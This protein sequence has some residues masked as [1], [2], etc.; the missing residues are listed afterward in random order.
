MDQLLAA[1]AEI[2][3]YFPWLSNGN[4]D[5]PVST[6]EVSLSHTSGYYFDACLPDGMDPRVPCPP[7]LIEDATAAAA[8]GGLDFT[9]I[10]GVII[11]SPWC[12]G[13]W[14]NGPISISRPGVSGTFQRAYD[15]ECD[16]SAILGLVNPPGPSR[17]WWGAWAHEIGHQLEFQYGLFNGAWNGHPGNYSSGYELMDSCYPCD[18]TSFSLSAPPVVSNIARVFP[19]WLPSSKV[20]TIDSS[21]SG[22]TVVL[23]PLSQDPVTTPA[24]Q[25]IQV[26]I[27]PGK[28]YMVEARRRLRADSLAT[29]PGIWDE[30]INIVD[31]EESRIPPALQ[32][33]SCNTSVPGGCVTDCA[34]DSR[35]GACCFLGTASCLRRGDAPDYCWPYP[36]W[37]VGDAFNDVAN[38][39]Q[40]RVDSE[41]GDCSQPTCGYAVT[42]T[43]G[44]TSGHPDI[45][46]LPWLTPPM[47]TW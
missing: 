41:V 10:G 24:A 36:L 40:I 9:G 11:L 43:R 15:F 23:A 28:Y 1:G 19:G 25:A 44:A 46:V 21:V 34:H 6:T 17:V 35:C 8:A 47:N 37:H 20:V 2:Q 33:N 4:L 14:T 29:A 5:M 12:A 39:I 18:S 30:G 26:P 45:Y 13:D 38:A 31:V 27:A 7:P 32:V 22:A 16:W 42:V 3:T